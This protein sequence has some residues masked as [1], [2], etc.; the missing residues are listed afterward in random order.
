M[1]IALIPLDS[2]VGEQLSAVCFVMDYVEFHFDGHIV[3][4]LN[5]PHAYLPASRVSF[6][7]SGSRDALCMFIGAVVASVAFEE[8]VALR[9]SFGE[10][11]ELVV[12]LDAAA[13]RGPEAL[14]WCPLGGP[15][16]VVQ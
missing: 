15:M 3:R 14:H 6:P 8:N 1:T 16:Q 9:L 10:R 2:L 11:G 4:A 12:P 13:T 7:E 5:N